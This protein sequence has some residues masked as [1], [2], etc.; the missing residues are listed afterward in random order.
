MDFK[1]ER[2]S[3]EEE[4]SN[5]HPNEAMAPRKRGLMN[6]L[7]PPGPKP[8]AGGRVKNHCRK[9]WWCDLLVIAVIALVVALPVVYVAIPKKAQHDISASTLEVQ[10]QEA[11]SP[12][13]DGVH[14]KLISVAKSGS[15]FHP[16]LDAFQAGLSVQGLA[17]FVYLNIPSIKAEAQT[18]IVVDQDVKV[19]NMDSFIAYNKLA[20]G[21]E[22]F[23]IDFNGKTKVHQSGLHAISVNYNKKVTMKGLNKLQGLNITDVKILFGD[24]QVLSDGSNMIGN[25]SIPN[26]S[27]ITFDLGNVTMNLSV[28]GQPI[29]YSLLPNLVIKPGYNFVPMQS[30][31]N[32]STVITL[33]TSGGPRPRVQGGV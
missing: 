7:Y 22:T 6:T 30:T 17:P 5:G 21:S 9:F 25:V 18:Q 24:S 13:P 20:L 29:G 4:V 14:L 31:V 33:I 19:S 15:D 32:Q 3:T 12:S 10:S 26:P 11:T 16:T 8:G 27:V 28:D 2:P 1:P 23:E